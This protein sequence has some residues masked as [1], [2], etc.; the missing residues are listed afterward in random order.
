MKSSLATLLVLIALCGHSQFNLELEIDTNKY[1]SVMTFSQLD[2][3]L[4]ADESV[5]IKTYY[6][7]TIRN[8]GVMILVLMTVRL[9]TIKGFISKM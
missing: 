5:I 6:S 3:L 9:F 4:K 8:N 7:L 1:D 2:A